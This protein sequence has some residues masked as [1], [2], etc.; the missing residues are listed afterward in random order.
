M[1]INIE[2]RP[3]LKNMKSDEVEYFPI[4]KAKNV[5]ATCTSLGLSDN[6]L[7]KTKQLNDL[8][9]IEVTKVN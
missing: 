7:F 6:M 4:Q 3:I 9:L 5:R 2:I 8:R 1:K